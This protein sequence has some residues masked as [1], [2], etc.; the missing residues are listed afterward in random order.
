MRDKIVGSPEEAIADLKD[1]DSVAVTGFGTSYGFP[2]SLLVATKEKNVKNLTLVT[3]ATDIA[4]V[5]TR[6]E[7]DPTRFDF[8]RCYQRV[9]SHNFFTASAPQVTGALRAVRVLS[10]GTTMS[11][12]G[13]G[14]QITQCDLVVK[15]DAPL[16]PTTIRTY[17]SAGAAPPVSVGQA[18]QTRALPDYSTTITIQ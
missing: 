13:N 2:V 14:T 5:E 9:T 8:A 18:G 10:F 11:P 3:N 17:A 15:A 7:F 16:G 12:V 4:G 1:G 6:L